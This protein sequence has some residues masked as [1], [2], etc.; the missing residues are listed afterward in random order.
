GEALEHVRNVRTDLNAFNDV[1]IQLLVYFGYKAAQENLA[2]LEDKPMSADS[3]KAT[4]RTIECDQNTGLPAAVGGDGWLP[5]SKEQM[6]QADPKR[7]L[8][9]SEKPPLFASLRWPL[10]FGVGLIALLLGGAVYV[11]DAQS[12]PSSL[13]FDAVFPQ[14]AKTGDE[15][16]F[17]DEVN[18]NP[19]LH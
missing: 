9:R 10:I 14:T 17:V 18:Q 6:A 3:T 16:T 11:R 13:S 2:A 19:V 15:K 7:D 8:S 4:T 12:A 5:F 1:E